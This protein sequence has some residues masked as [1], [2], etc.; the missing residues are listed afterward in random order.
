[1]E[2]RPS[3]PFNLREDGPDE[4]YFEKL[5]LQYPIPHDYNPGGDADPSL[6]YID[7]DKKLP[8]TSSSAPLKMTNSTTGATN[9]STLP[10]RSGSRKGRM[11]SGTDSVKKFRD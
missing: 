2:T 5:L 6:G 10:R 4:E 3:V 1:M 9:S 11:N 8:V 7:L